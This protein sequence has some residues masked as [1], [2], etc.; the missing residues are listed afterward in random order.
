MPVVRTCPKCNNPVPPSESNCPACD[1]FVSYPNVDAARL[2]DEKAALQRRY[3]SAKSECALR[4]SE[5]Q[6]LAFET[7]VRN[8]SKA[9]MVR[10]LGEA[11]TLASSEKR[12]HATY[13]QQLWG[14][15][16]LPDG[17]EWDLLRGI[18]GNTLFPGYSDNIQFALLTLN[19][20]G[21]PHYGEIC[22]VLKEGTISNRAS[23]FEEIPRSTS[24]R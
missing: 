3:D 14:G 24:R 4:K 23:V 8:K 20:R 9:V 12:L 16:R 22:L 17:G 19:E 21:S 13:E 11:T 2:P 5:G 6:L 18:A 1:G 7:D 15:A 10:R